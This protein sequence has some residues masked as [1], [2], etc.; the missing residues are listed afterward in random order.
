L[1]KFSAFPFSKLE[2]MLDR[3]KH[4]LR[5][6]DWDAEAILGVIDS[7]I[8]LKK[9]VKARKF[10][11]PLLGHTI[12]LYFEK[13]SLRTITTF[14]VGMAQL[15]GEAVQLDAGSIGL[16]QRES[17]ADVARCLGR[18]VDGI[19]VR[20]FAQSLLEELAEESGVPVINALTDDSHPCQALALGQTLTERF[21]E[22][23]GRRI[24]FVG[25]GNNVANSFAVM[26]AK[27]GMHFVHTGPSGYEQ[28]REVVDELLPL[29][30]KTGGSYLY[31]R[32]PALAVA[33][34]DLVY[35]DVWT[36]MGQEAERQ[37]RLKQFAPW[38]VDEALMSKAPQTAFFSHCLPAHRGEEVT[39]GVMDSPQSLCFD[40][41]EN[42]LHAH[43]AV[44][45]KLL[46]STAR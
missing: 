17:V 3:Q 1:A 8:A 40:E 7:A 12:A 38:C 10:P 18:W 20:T 43:K 25:D 35:T 2:L 28:K 36:S 4:L 16:G 44:I 46:S 11:Y 42:R 45:L 27:L 9:E 33:S 32:D 5:L 39:D 24:V 41:A 30:K 19:V 14:K 21:G 26:A 31:E 29:F 23:K 22:L 15:G 6:M 37:E 34:A 13:Q